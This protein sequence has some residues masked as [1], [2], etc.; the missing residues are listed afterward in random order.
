VI[1]HRWFHNARTS[2]FQ[3]AIPHHGIDAWQ[4]WK[5]RGGELKTL[6]KRAKLITEA[7]ARYIIAHGTASSS[8]WV[9][10]QHMDQWL[11]IRG[12]TKTEI[13]ELIEDLD[14]KLA[15]DLAAGIANPH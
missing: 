5:S 8:E 10:V 7:E 12:M 1:A 6:Y 14:R 4:Q 3:S 9:V 2:E 15:A 11:D 13:T